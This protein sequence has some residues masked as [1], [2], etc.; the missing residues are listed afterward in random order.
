MFAFFLGEN[1]KQLSFSVGVFTTFIEILKRTSSVLP[2]FWLIG[3]LSTGDS[4]KASALDCI[5]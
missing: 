2:A 4:E 3:L 5:F 1:G